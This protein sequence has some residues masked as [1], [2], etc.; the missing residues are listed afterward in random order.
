MQDSALLISG[1]IGADNVITAQ[2]TQGL[3]AAT[4]SAYS[5]DLGT[6][7][8]IGEGQAIYLKAIAASG[9]SA[10]ASANYTAYNSAT[11]YVR[12]EKCSF[13]GIDYSCINANGGYAAYD[14]GTAY[15]VG[16][17]C[18]YS[19][20]SYGCILA[21]TNNL[22]TNETYWKLISPP[23]STY[24]EVVPDS[25]EIQLVAANNPA[26]TTGLS[27]LATTGPITVYP[28]YVPATAYAVGD[29]VT[30]EGRNFNCIQAG[31]GKKPATNPG[32]WDE[33]GIGI[34]DG[35][36]SYLPVPV[37]KN[38]RGK[39]YLGARYIN[40]G[41]VRGISFISEFTTEVSD[42]LKFY[43]SGFSV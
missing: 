1:T 43:P 23:N 40:I 31:A 14:A 7:R 24:W 15:A 3:N 19:G 35:L 18:S 39:R 36:V 17:K 34:S 33:I 13:G 8:D 4:L 22:P 38:S 30:S 16:N 41:D 9:A 42:P 20:K 12:G 11:T 21:T 28:L 37:Q 2:S 27:V 6:V 10:V 25:V 5:V 29:K 26:L 32:Y